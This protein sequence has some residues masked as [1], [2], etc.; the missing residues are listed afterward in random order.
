MFAY[1]MKPFFR[2]GKDTPWGGEKLRLLFHKDIPDA[3]TG[4]S[5]EISTYFDEAS[6]TGESRTEDGR[7]LSEVL[8][9]PLPLLL[10]LIDAKQTLSVQVHPDDAYAHAH[11]NGKKGKTEAWLILQAEPGAKLVYGMKPG[12]D[13]RRLTRESV[14]QHLHWVPVQAGDV[15]YI[16]AG[17]VHAIGE[18]IVLYEIQQA[19]DITYRLWDWNRLQADGSPRALHF[20]KACD[21]I[22]L[23]D[24]EAPVAGVTHVCGSGMVTSYLDTE[25]FMLKRLHVNGHMP[26]PEMEGFAFLTALCAGS[27]CCEGQTLSFQTG[28][29]FFIPDA[30]VGITICAQ[31]DLLLSGLGRA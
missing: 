18:G 29:S 17:M 3:K 27:L 30:S 23:Q 4:E 12:T 26:L 8:G 2:H 20:E 5:L 22:R 21:V 25:Y 24:I 13:C 14:E 16:P 10:K 7:T 1:R 15:F 19:S 11:E 9:K 31:G 28:E 6:H